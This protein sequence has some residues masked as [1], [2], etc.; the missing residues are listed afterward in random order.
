MYVKL[1]QPR[2]LKRP[3]DTDLKTRMSPPLG[4][5]TVMNV[6][7]DKHHVSIENGN[8]LQD[9]YDDG[10]LILILLGQNDTQFLDFFL[11]LFFRQQ[12]FLNIL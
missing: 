5:L 2:M 4:L 11:N 3:M 9:A 7:K 12:N 6:L 8:T 1:I 10:V